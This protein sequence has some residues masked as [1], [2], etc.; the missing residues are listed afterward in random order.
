MKKDKETS[1]EWVWQI[2]KKMEDLLN[3]QEKVGREVLIK[4][5]Q[6]NKSGTISPSLC[7]RTVLFFCHQEVERIVIGSV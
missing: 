1:N 3:K 6:S 5:G 7:I 2:R 4:N